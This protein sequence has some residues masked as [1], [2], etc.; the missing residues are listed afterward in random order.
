MNAYVKDRFAGRKTVLGATV[1]LM[2]IAMALVM[3][4]SAAQVSAKSTAIIKR[5]PLS[6][7]A[8]FPAVNGEAK[9]KAKEGERELEIQIEDAKRL[10]GKRLTVRIGGK[11]M[12]HMRVS[13]LG[14]ARLVRDT[15]AGQSVPTSVTGKGVRISTAGGALVASG[16]F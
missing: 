12:G 5:A 4:A 7:S 6:G 16:R 8:A 13:A 14:R 10:A 9:W 2:L 1:G 11:V 15:Q 3:L